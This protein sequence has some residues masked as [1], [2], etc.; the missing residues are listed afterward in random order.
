MNW[1][2]RHWG[3]VVAGA[4]LVATGAI[5][6]ASGGNPVDGIAKILQGIGTIVQEDKTP[7]LDTSSILQAPEPSK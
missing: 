5:S 4:V 2:K 3:K 6:L 7:Q 1:L